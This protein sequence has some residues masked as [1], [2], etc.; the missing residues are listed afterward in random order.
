LLPKADVGL[1]TGASVLVDL[2]NDGALDVYLQKQPT[3]SLAERLRKALDAEV[4]VAF[5]GVRFGDVL[6]NLQNQVPGLVFRNLLERYK[7]G[8]PPVT[9]EV[10]EPMPV[11]ALLQALE[12]EL[13]P[14]ALEG[15]R[16]DPV[17]FVVRDYG[18]LV[19]AQSKVPPGAVLL[20]NFAR[21][22]SPGPDK[23]AGGEAPSAEAP[24]VDGEVTQVDRQSGLVTISK[25]GDAGVQEG[26]R[27]EVYRLNPPR[28]CGALRVLRATPHNAVGKP[29]GRTLQPFQVGDRVTN[30][31]KK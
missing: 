23:P 17:R 13:P 25:G 6:T 11:R 9:I 12:D 14:L 28:Y 18:I 20:H 2:D 27:L 30:Q 21:P 15:G 29:E 16:E 4:K 24:A 22:E 19:T 5:K 3:G 31:L 1:V 26:H 7:D 8:N 10:K